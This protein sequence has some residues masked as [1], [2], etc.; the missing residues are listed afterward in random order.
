MLSSASSPLTSPPPLLLPHHPFPS[1]S[2]LTSPPPPSSACPFTQAT[3]EARSTQL[4]ALFDSLDTDGSG[5][6]DQAE[7]ERVTRT[8]HSAIWMQVTHLHYTHSQLD[9]TIPSLTS[10]FRVTS[11]HLHQTL[12]C[13]L[14]LPSVHPFP[15]DRLTSTARH[16]THTNPPPLTPPPGICMRS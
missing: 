8:T 15:P 7:L 1:P 3:G 16:T 10:L 14:P 2:R 11:C 12:R 5:D 6:I 4:R 13:R 9:F